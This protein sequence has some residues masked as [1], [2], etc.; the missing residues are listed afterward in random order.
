MEN[1]QMNERSAASIHRLYFIHS[2]YSTACMNGG[3]G[4][5]KG[6]AGTLGMAGPLALLTPNAM[7]IDIDRIREH[8]RM[9]DFY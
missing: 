4:G 2:G 6:I 9:E 1:R 7:E 3:G 8:Q 5:W